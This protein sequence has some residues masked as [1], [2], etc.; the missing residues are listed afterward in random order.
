MFISFLIL[1]PII[2]K[3]TEEPLDLNK[4]QKA[5]ITGYVTISYAMSH[6]H[7]AISTT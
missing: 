4:F 1:L 5:T 6:K 2:W 3:Y 7:A